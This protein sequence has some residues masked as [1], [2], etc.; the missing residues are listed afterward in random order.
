METRRMKPFES[1]QEYL[2]VMRGL[3]HKGSLDG[4]SQTE[5]VINGIPNS[6]NNKIILNSCKSIFEF[7]ENIKNFGK[8]FTSSKQLKQNNQE[9]FDDIS[10]NVKLNSKRIPNTIPVC[11]SYGLRDHKSDQRM[12]K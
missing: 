5:Y 1:L 3:T 12:N 4:F 9:K 11:Y 10:Y 8:P 2:L 6:S 7:S